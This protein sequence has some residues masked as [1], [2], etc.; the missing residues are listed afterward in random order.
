MSDPSQSEPLSPRALQRRLKK[1]LLKRD[2]AFFSICTP[3]F[4]DLMLRELRGLGARDP[5]TEPGGV[6][7]TGPFELAYRINFHT[8]MATRLLVRVDSFVARSL[9]ELF[10][11]A[12][13]V[14]WELWLGMG[15]EVSFEVASSTSRL[16]HTQTIAS[17]VFDGIVARTKP[18][19]I[20]IVRTPTSALRV[21]V[22]FENDR[23]TLSM[24]ASGE[25]LYKRGYRTDT[26]HAPIRETLASSLLL[27]SGWHRFPVIADP[28]CGSGTFL[29]EAASMAARR[30]AGTLRGFAF[31]QWPSFQQGKYAREKEFENQALVETPACPPRFVGMDLSRTALQA[32]CANAQRAGVDAAIRLAEGDCREFNHD[33]SLGSSGLVISNPPYGK[34]IGSVAGSTELLREFGAHLRKVC[35]GWHF[36]FVLPRGKHIQATGLRPSL[37]RVFKNGG[38]D[39]AFYFGEIG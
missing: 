4:E 33:R 14:H 28:M 37:T 19:G 25:A 6:E 23:C 1:Y 21:F 3:G 13:R 30:P 22:R 38:L 27:L 24:D 2:H 10:G 34:R 17:A 32:A 26:A 12:K 35:K 39:V 31:E 9:P 29:I 11:K 7:C 5:H 15:S 8:R 20:D 18:L 16:H 36:G